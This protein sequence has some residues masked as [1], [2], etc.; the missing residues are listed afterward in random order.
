M[1]AKDID[2]LFDDKGTAKLLI[3]LQNESNLKAKINDLRH[4]TA[5]GKQLA[6][7]IKQ[8]RL[9]RSTEANN[10]ALELI[11]KI[12]DVLRAN[13]NDIYIDMLK[14]YGQRETESFLI[15]NNP[16]AIEMIQKQFDNHCTC[17][18]KREQNGTEYLECVILKGSSQYDTREMS[19]LIDGIVY[20]A[21]NLNIETITPDE[22]ARMKSL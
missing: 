9:K 19:I 7:D 11:G 10:Y 4:L 18:G 20:E 22:L 2:L 17:I 8:Y 16:K 12:A 15:I 6:I 13:K 21:Q 3:I 14:K 5:E 1:I